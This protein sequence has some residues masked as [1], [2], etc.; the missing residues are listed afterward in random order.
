MAFAYYSPV[1][2]QSAQVPSAQTDFPMLVS[3]TDNRLKTVGNGGHVQNASGYDIRPYSDSGLTS[4]MTYEL[5]FYDATNGIIVMWVKVASINTGSIVY[6][7]Y[8][9]AALNTNG[10]STSTWDS[11]FVAVYH[12]HDNAASTTVTDST[13]NANGT[14]TNNTST[15]TIT[16]QI[17]GGLNF[18]AASLD[19]VT[20]PN[21][22][23]LNVNGPITMSTWIKT[24]TTNPKNIIQGYQGSGS[25]NG[26]GFSINQGTNGKFGYW[27]GTG[28]AA[29]INSNAT[30]VNNGSWHLI[31]VT[32]TGT[33]LNLYLDGAL[34]RTTTALQDDSYAGLRYIAFDSFGGGGTY[35]DANL[36]EIRISNAVRSTDWVAT[37]YNNQSAP[38]TFATLGTE[39]TVGAVVATHNLSAINA[40]T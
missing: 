2:V 34:D 3:Y 15:K 30:T 16:A 32:E 19:K 40:G 18:V 26:Y 7:A 29:W 12:M 4:A 14:N 11:N 24:T 35:T 8:G 39:V 5:E 22:A 33:T 28:S 17:D 9:D 20:L 25:F 37:E 23:A 10:S 21:V 27:G 6:L 1:T 38:S 36:D 31:A 13:G